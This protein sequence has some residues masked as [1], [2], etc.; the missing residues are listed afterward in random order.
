MSYS[1]RGKP[2]QWMTKLPKPVLRLRGSSF[3]RSTNQAQRQ[4][5][6]LDICTTAQGAYYTRYY[7]C[8][9]W[10]N[11]PYF[12]AR[13]LA[14]WSIYRWGRFKTQTLPPPFAKVRSMGQLALMT[15]LKRAARTK[16]T[17]KCEFNVCCS[18]KAWTCSH[19]YQNWFI[20][21]RFTTLGVISNT[22]EINL[23]SD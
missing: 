23:T 12:R 8:S 1:A 4:I 18:N 2:E 16:H 19:Y 15:W 17:F 9:I 6:V 7:A 13:V 20:G 22:L 11:S 3:A 21:L 5:L 10:I 14:A